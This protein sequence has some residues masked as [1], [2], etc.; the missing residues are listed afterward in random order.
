MKL[1]DLCMDAKPI[2]LV[3]P[4]TIVVFFPQ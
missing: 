4:F 3:K 2:F 1:S